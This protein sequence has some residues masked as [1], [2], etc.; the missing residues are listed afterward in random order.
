MLVNI[1][2]YTVN[3]ICTTREII[4]LRIISGLALISVLFGVLYWSIYFHYSDSI[5]TPVLSHIIDKNKNISDT[6]L[7]PT[8]L[9]DT[10][11][12]IS[13]YNSLTN[14]E[15]QPK[16]EPTAHETIV[17][18]RYGTTVLIVLAPVNAHIAKA[19]VLL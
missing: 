7:T 10:L 14:D 13:D 1:L 5:S 6:T 19:R 16:H 8:I 18:I 9:K 11:S 2:S 3:I 17:P 12:T 15:H 4:K